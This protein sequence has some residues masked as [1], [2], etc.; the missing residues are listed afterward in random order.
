M[1]KR[2]S[3]LG[4]TNGGDDAVSMTWDD[5]LRELQKVL[6]LRANCIVTERT[7][8]QGRRLRAG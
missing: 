2:M 5:G 4:S 7:Q 3:M 8:Q 6:G 1:S